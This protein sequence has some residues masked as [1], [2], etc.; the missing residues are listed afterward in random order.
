MLRWNKTLLTEPAR[1]RLKGNLALI[2]IATYQRKRPIAGQ[3]QAS[4]S[5][6]V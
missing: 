4:R 5:Q 1:N 2:L 3:T 6:C